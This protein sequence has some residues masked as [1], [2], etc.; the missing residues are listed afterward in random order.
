MTPV[1][2]G[3]I[4]ASFPPKSLLGPLAPGRTRPAP[5]IDPIEDYYQLAHH[6][7]WYAILRETA[8]R[9]GALLDVGSG[10]G[11]WLRVLA[12]VWPELST[13]KE[14][15]SYSSLDPSPGVAAK[16]ASSAAVFSTVKGHTASTIQ[17]AAELPSGQFDLIWAMHSLYSLHPSEL[18]IALRAIVD[19]LSPGGLA[20][21][22][23]S[24]GESFYAKACAELTDDI[25]FLLA[26]DVIAGA[27]RLGL[28]FRVD[29][30]H[31]EEIIAASDDESLRRYLWHES[32][33]NTYT[34]EGGFARDQLPPL[35]DTTWWNS[36]RRGNEF[37]FAQTVPVISIF[38]AT[39]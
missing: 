17:D 36:F 31:Y 12:H 33:G 4:S 29:T 34:P 28:D 1:E 8:S 11:R 19:A 18:P 2:S 13:L 7:D 24:N 25:R 3:Q 22:A 23:L 26:D 30:I 39:A 38:K 5:A 6:F 37:A 32:I 16:A 10:T 14:S 35:P 20:V 9:G 15:L 21:I 27:K